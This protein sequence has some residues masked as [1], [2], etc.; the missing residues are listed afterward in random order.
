MPLAVCFFK[1]EDNRF[2]VLC[3]FLRYNNVSQP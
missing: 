1:L 2:T 3:Y